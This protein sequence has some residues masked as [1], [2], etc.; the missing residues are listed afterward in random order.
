M[1][2]T[3]IL[4][5]AAC[6]AASVAS[7]QN[8]LLNGGFDTPASGA[9]P[10][11]WS[12]WSWGDGWANH[13]N[14]ASASY[15]GSYY[16]VCGGSNLGAGGGGFNQ[17]VAGNAGVTYTL[18]VLSGADAWWLPYGEMRLFFL[19]DANDTLAN[20]IQPTVD[21]AVYGQNYD[22][23][24]PWSEYTL[25]ATA[26]AGTTQV[27]VEFAE[28]SGQGSVWFENAS[29]TASVVYP[30]ITN[31]YPDGASLMQA[32]NAF[33]FT[34]YS[35]TTPINDSGIQVTVNGVDVSASLGI[36]GSATI[37]NVTYSGLTT[38][39]TYAVVVHV[40]D[41]N[42]LMVSRTVNFDTFSQNY[43]SWEAEDWNYNGGLFVDNPQTNAY[44]GLAGI[45]G[46]DYLETSAGTN[47]ASWSY[48]AWT[49]PTIP[50][51]QTEVS[52]D[53][54]RP[55]YAGTNDYDIGWFDAGEWLDYTRTFPAG[56][57]NV[58]A[59]MASPGASTL[60]LSQ[61]TGGLGTDGQTT[62]SLGNFA[63]QNGLGWTVYSWVPL[64]DAG[65]NLIKL[66]LNGGETFRATSGGNAN[67]NFFMLVP[68]NTNAPVIT[69]LYPDG[70][71]LLQATNT[72]SF[73]V[74]SPAGVNA[75]N[76]AVTLNI[77][78]NELHYSTN[79][80]SAAGLVIGG[81]PN[82]VTV[83]YPGLLSN[84]LYS[85]VITVTDMAGNTV[86]IKP[87][88]DTYVPVLTWEAEDYDYN[89]GQFINN[90]AVD[91]YA[92]MAGV[93]GIDFHDVNASG[94]PVYRPDAMATG[95][96]GDIPRVQYLS[97]ATN[98]YSIGYFSVPEWVNY[99]RT[100][101]A[102]TYNIYARLAAGGGNSVQS[103]G[104]VTNGAGTS[105]QQVMAL[106]TFTGSTAGWG[107]YAYFPLR[108][109]LGNLA[110]VALSGTTT[111]KLQ[112]AS[113]ADANA[114]FL[115]LLP[116]DNGL[117]RVSQV[118]PTGW[119]QSTNR[120]RFVVTSAA[121]IATNNV[122]VKLNNIPSSSLTFSG[123]ANDW[124]VACVLAPST[125]YT[126][127]ITV[128]DNNGQVAST[129][130]SFDTFSPSS[131]TWEAEDYDYNAGLF[132]D[133]PQVNG[134]LGLGGTSGIDYNRVSSGGAPLYRADSVATETCGDLSRP[135]YIGGSYADYDVGYT[136]AGDWWNYT[137]TYPAGRFNVYLRAARGSGGSAPPGLQQVT[138]GWG[139]AN[140][141][142]RPLGSFN[143]PDTGDWQTYAWVSLTNTNGLPAVVALDGTNTLRL[144]DGGANLNFLLLSP[145]PFINAAMSGSTINLSFGTQAGFDYTVLYADQVN[146]GTWN[147][148]NSVAGDGT[149]KTLSGPISGATRFYRLQ[150]H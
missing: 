59:R 75:N 128:T 95:I 135:Q 33:V 24:H 92:N 140:Q 142:T 50:V 144:T 44:S 112:R 40:T 37:R 55:Q 134:Y 63:Q 96:A 109:Q 100:F 19:D 115:M 47:S 43:Y 141:S 146:A 35:T 64:T 137:R 48:R 147:V 32:T 9:T 105:S 145:A 39:K 113:G 12:A 138:G 8:L 86:T 2:K 89:G 23:L 101:P 42:G 70:A 148:L 20:P 1:K 90:P 150:I 65:G 136:A 81:T 93:E 82:N 62:S 116:A 133:N 66:D 107:T 14:N 27:K 16:V 74:A 6:M 123:S 78:N 60:N 28:P 45:P 41:A 54:K 120:L 5:S 18:S 15:D 76:I 125:V 88:F 91:A 68:A 52:P 30:V 73:V 129:T 26:P 79:L 119:L 36:S 13:E 126:A 67:V 7:A 46:I 34:A 108:D 77:T 80:T 117:P 110:Q 102:G 111:L 53:L 114:N 3:L 99:T 139:T 25:T 31:L 69:R 58:Y 71:T 83:S 49:D 106:G 132:I 22:I 87:G 29:L 38:N 103:L 11:N 10:D 104:I 118:T 124:S 98:D 149:T 127:N 143:V 72:L 131:Y 97:P 130:V 57:Y 85:A 61:V 56:T 84:T 94:V 21:P 122:V 4:L 51:P 17:I 121:G